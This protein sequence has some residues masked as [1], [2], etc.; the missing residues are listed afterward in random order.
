MRMLVDV[1]IPNEPFNSMVKDGSA[2]SAIEKALGA[3]KPEA[4]YFTEREGRRGC[5]LVVDLSDASGVP[6]IAEPFFLL[7]NA[8]VQLHPVMS[9]EDL[10]RAG[11]EN[12]GRMYA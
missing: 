4:V 10:G 3:V 12:I 11:L 9:P 1:S 7:F 2:G 5:T 8:S 6:S